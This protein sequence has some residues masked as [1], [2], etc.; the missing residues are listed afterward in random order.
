MSKAS[1]ADDVL[2]V[3]Y[4]MLPII[5]YICEPT[6]DKAANNTPKE[7]AVNITLDA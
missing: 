1:K 3:C 7:K 4:E 5:D 2:G 6:S